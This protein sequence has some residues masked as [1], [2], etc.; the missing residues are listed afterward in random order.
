MFNKITKEIFPSLGRCHLGERGIQTTNMT[1]EEISNHI[2]VKA[3]KEQN[4]RKD[5][6]RRIYK[7]EGSSHREGW[8]NRITA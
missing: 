6:E 3:L 7:R 8:V 2:L 4:S 5:S 1:K